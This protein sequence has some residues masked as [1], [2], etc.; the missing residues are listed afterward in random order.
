MQMAFAWKTCSVERREKYPVNSPNGPSG[1]RTR[2]RIS[3]S[4]TISAAAGTARSIVAHGATS[5]GSPN[6]P[7][8]TSN[9]P[10]SA[11]G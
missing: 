4:I 1:S 8:T 2:G 11:G 5:S 10:T 9:F 6:S 3:P 7:P